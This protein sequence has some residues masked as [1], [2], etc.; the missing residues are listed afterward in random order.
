MTDWNDYT[1]G[2]VVVR[3]TERSRIQHRVLRA[4]QDGVLSNAF[5]LIGMAD[6]FD[7]YGSEMR[8]SNETRYVKALG[9]PVD[10]T[11]HQWR[12]YKRYCELATVEEYETQAHV[13]QQMRDLT[14][15]LF[16]PRGLI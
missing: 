1:D 14:P 3:Y 10:R 4:V 7:T 8:D 6:E 13:T 5:V 11:A 2:I 15:Q 16:G 12:V 9:I